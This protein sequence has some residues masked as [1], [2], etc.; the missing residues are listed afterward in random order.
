MFLFPINLNPYES[1]WSSCVCVWCNCNRAEKSRS[2]T[3]Y[4][5]VTN[6]VAPL[7]FFFWPLYL[8]IYGICVNSTRKNG[9]LIILSAHTNWC[10]FTIIIIIIVNVCIE[11]TIRKWF[12]F[13]CNVNAILCLA[14]RARPR[15]TNNDDVTFSTK[16]RCGFYCVYTFYAQNSIYHGVREKKENSEGKQRAKTSERWSA[17]FSSMAES[18]NIFIIIYVH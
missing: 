8:Q 6:C 15:R 11:E 16:T 3:R 18:V 10:S 7:S 14:N 4:R 5:R 17:H 13:I 2:Y 12:V 1:I 9:L